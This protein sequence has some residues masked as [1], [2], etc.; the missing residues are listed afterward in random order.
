MNTLINDMLQQMPAVTLDEMTNL[1]LMERVDCKYVSSI[2]LLPRLLEGMT[3]LFKVQTT[4]G[5]SI[6]PYSTQYM[7]TPGLE[8]FLMH[9]NGKLNRQ[10]IRIRSYLESN[11]S[12]LEI[13]SKNNKGLTSKKRIPISLSHLSAISDLAENKRF[14]DEYAIFNSDALEPAL[15]NRFN[16]LTFV[17]NKATERITI[18]WNLSFINC[19]TGKETALDNLIVLEL[20]QDGRQ[21]SDFRDILHRQQIHPAS[22]SKYCIG[23]I[24]T[25]PHV[26]YNR[27][28]NK[29]RA[30]NKLTN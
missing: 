4:E 23:T 12:F 27:F 21:L 19:K 18:D 1:R 14:L 6:S 28:K 30:I 9:Q 17:N 25:N 26:K 5:R 13:K 8:M 15:A 24:L 29:L 16:R 3:P 7:D 20:K 11:L 2:S 10:K 22:F